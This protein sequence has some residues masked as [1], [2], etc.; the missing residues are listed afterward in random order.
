MLGWECNYVCVFPWHRFKLC[1][2]HGSHLCQW[3][4]QTSASWHNH[5]YKFIEKQDARFDWKTTSMHLSALPVVKNLLFC[6]QIQICWHCTAQNR[7]QCWTDPRQLP[8]RSFFYKKKCRADIQR[9]CSILTW[10]AILSVYGADTIA[11]VLLSIFPFLRWSLDLWNQ[12]LSF[13]NS[14]LH[15]TISTLLIINLHWFKKN[16]LLY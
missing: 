14:K 9:Q 7:F 2:I 4:L 5:L 13:Y 15:A 6:F 10:I 16:I 3:K 12:L 1:T 11:E 8:N